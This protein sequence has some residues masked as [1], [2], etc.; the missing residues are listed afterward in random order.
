MRDYI[1][2]RIN[3]TAHYIINNS[4]TVRDAAKVFCISKSTVHKDM[5]ERLRVVNPRL[6]RQVRHV[7]DINKAERHIRGGQATYRKYKGD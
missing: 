6:Y 3:E 7:L 5:A 2:E 1:E 4:A